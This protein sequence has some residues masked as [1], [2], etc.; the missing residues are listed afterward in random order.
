MPG[1]SVRSGIATMFETRATQG[2]GP[3]P[4]SEDQEPG[5]RATLAAVLMIVVLLA[6]GAYLI[7]VLRASSSLEDCL[8]QGRTNCA[9]IAKSP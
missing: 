9:P 3:E 5:H 7:H 2:H 6:V 8:M 1:V 4:S